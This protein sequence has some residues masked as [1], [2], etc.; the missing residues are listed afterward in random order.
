MVLEEFVE[1]TSPLLQIFLILTYD[2]C[3]RSQPFLWLERQLKASSGTSAPR[4]FFFSLARLASLQIL[5]KRYR[6]DGASL[7]AWSMC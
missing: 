6:K 7:C 5:E 2:T 1:N 3:L 4:V